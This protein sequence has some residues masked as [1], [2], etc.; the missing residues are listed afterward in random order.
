MILE[1]IN[2]IKYKK[3]RNN[4]YYEWKVCKICKKKRYMKKSCVACDSLEN[5]P[6]CTVINRRLSKY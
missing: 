5:T 1:K 6:K 4:K 2:K 3:K